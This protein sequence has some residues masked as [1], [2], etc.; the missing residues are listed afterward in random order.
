LLDTGH[1]NLNGWDAAA[2]IDR[3][4]D[5]LYGVH[6]HDN[7]ADTDGHLPIGEGNLGWPRVFKALRGI[8]GDC[9][10]VL[11]YAPG[12]PLERL[13]EGREILMRNLEE[14]R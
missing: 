11:E 3:L 10:V 5:R 9:D 7:M 1:A 8:G 14:G 13:N 4:K 12:T 2:L 6:L